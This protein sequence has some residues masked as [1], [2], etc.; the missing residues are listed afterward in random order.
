MTSASDAQPLQH[1]QS[2]IARKRSASNLKP[3]PT[4]VP[5]PPAA[6]RRAATTR[7]RPP[8]QWGDIQMAELKPILMSPV[9]A[10]GHARM[11][12]C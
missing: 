2:R 5:V 6:L 4:R 12:S 11:I 10:A 8:T 3:A 9:V 1:L 7:A